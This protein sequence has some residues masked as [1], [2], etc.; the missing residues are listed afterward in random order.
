MLAF[1]PTFSLVSADTARVIVEELDVHNPHT[2][3]I[4]D[5]DRLVGLEIKTRN[6]GSFIIRDV[7]GDVLVGTPVKK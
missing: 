5:A 4:K 6:H 3:P 2:G 1:K 7:L